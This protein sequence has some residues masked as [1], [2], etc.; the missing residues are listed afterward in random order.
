MNHYKHDG[1]SHY[2]LIILISID[3]SS[4]FSWSL[5]Y[6]ALFFLYLQSHKL[7]LSSWL[8]KKHILIPASLHM[9]LK[10]ISVHQY[11]FSNFLLNHC[12]WKP[13]SLHMSDQKS[14]YL[15]MPVPWIIALNQSQHS[16][17]LAEAVWIAFWLLLL[18][19]VYL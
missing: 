3:M 8:F 2:H 12:I 10:L 11:T 17:M 1:P 19:T 9:Q 7:W 5:P 15:Q 14:Y 13:V 6:L 4:V 18:F 16:S